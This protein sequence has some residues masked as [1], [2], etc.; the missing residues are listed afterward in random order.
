MTAQRI[1]L[2]CAI[3]FA[4]GYFVLNTV[5]AKAN[6]PGDIKRVGWT[7]PTVGAISLATDAP[8]GWGWLFDELELIAS[9]KSTVYNPSMTIEEM[10][11]KWT[12]TQPED[13]ASNVADFLGVLVTTP[14]AALL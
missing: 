2:A 12:T 13:W 7:G 5:P 1:R 3:A 14:L 4:E 11:A 6:N 9:R 10:A 8:T